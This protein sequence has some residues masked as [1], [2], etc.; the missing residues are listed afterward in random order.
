ML[1]FIQEDELTQEE[2]MEDNKDTEILAKYQ[3]LGAYFQLAIYFKDYFEVTKP[4][5][6]QWNQGKQ[7]CGL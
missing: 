3:T 5:K 7:N 4:K 2:L 6:K 1:T